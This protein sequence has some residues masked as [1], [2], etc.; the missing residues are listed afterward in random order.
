MRKWIPVKLGT[1]PE[2]EEV[3]ITYINRNPPSY[4]ATIKDKPFTGAAVYCRGRWFWY[5]ATCL[6]YCEE[7]GFSDG[8]DMDDWI[9]VTAWMPLPEPYKAESEDKK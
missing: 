5:S 9:E 4:Y 6:D 7:Y 8:D 3:L 2:C 1:P